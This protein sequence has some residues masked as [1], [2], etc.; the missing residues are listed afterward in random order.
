MHLEKP[1]RLGY[2]I[3]RLNLTG[4]LPWFEIMLL[5]PPASQEAKQSWAMR[6]RLL[7]C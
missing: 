1:K 6:A 7:H 5:W 2:S 3:W 4:F